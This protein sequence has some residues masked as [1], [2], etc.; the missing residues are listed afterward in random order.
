M[1]YK[2]DKTSLR[3]G[4][5]NKCSSIKS[6]AIK[7]SWSLLYGV[8]T[9]YSDSKGIWTSLSWEVVGKPYEC[10][11]VYVHRSRKPARLPLRQCGAEGGLLAGATAP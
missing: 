10:R 9:S 6:S 1:G 8:K 7:L 4:T 5:R 11:R 2:R 3:V